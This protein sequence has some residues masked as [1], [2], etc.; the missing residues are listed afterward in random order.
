MTTMSIS[1]LRQDYQRGALM[2]TEVGGDPIA[3]FARWF[4]E[5]RAAVREPNAMILATVDAGGQPTARTLLLKEFGERGFVFFTNQHSR[6]AR[7]LAANPRAAMLFF[8]A[9]LE[10]QVRIEGSAWP[11]GTAEADAYFMQRPLGSRYGAWASPQSEPIAGREVLEARLA[12]IEER[13]PA[14]DGPPRPPHW[15]GYCLAPTSIEFW[16]GRSSRLHDRLLYRREEAGWT[17]CR[18]AP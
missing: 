5:A 10:R 2:E 8:W 4:D 18:L 17:R 16:Q 9:E 1:D 15:G 11:V 14:P 3:L 7:E 12:E 13:F 6:K